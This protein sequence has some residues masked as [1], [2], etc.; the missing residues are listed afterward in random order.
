MPHQGCYLVQVASVL[1]VHSIETNDTHHDVCNM[2][3]AQALEL[4]LCHHDLNWCGFQNWLQN[5]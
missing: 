4:L 3:C 5:V 2:T 1:H